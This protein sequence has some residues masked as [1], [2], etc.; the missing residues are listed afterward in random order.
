MNDK[1]PR[2]IQI[3]QHEARI[4]TLESEVAHIRSE[5]QRSA[6]QMIEDRAKRSGFLRGIHFAATIIG[7]TVIIG[8]LIA[9][10]KFAGAL[11]AFIKLLSSI[12]L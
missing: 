10:E 4:V 8:A 2:D 9:S 3:G 11:S 7:Y 5:V 12:K 6:A 1:C